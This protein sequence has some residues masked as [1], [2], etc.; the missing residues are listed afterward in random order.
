M[1]IKIILIFFLTFNSLFSQNPTYDWTKHLS[2]GGSF[3]E[4][5]GVDHDSSGN[6][7]TVGYFNSVMDFDPSSSNYI[8]SSKGKDDMFIQKLDGNGNFIWAVSFG[9]SEYSDIATDVRI[10]DDDNV[11]VTG[12]FK[13]SID[14]DP[15]SNVYEVI[16]ANYYKNFVLKLNNSGNLIWVKAFGRTSYSS[17]YSSV[18]VDNSGNIYTTGYFRDTAD[19]NPS[20]DTF[21]V[22]SNG[23]S[24]VF[25]HKLDYQGN[26]SWVR[27]MGGQY[28]DIGHSIV[29]SNSGYVYSTGEFLSTVDFNTDRGTYYRTSNGIRDYY[30]HKLDING[31]FVWA[32]TAGGFANEI[33][34]GIVLDTNE[35]VYFV[36]YM[37]D[38]ADFDPSDA[39]Y[40]VEIDGNYNAFIAKLNSKGDFQWAK[41]IGGTN[42]RSIANDIA[43]DNENKLYVVGTFQYTADFDF[44]TETYPLTSNGEDDF[45]ALKIDQDSNFIWAKPIGGLKWDI[46]YGVQTGLLNELY[47][48]GAFMNSVDFNFTSNADIKVGSYYSLAYKIFTTK[49]KNQEVL[50]IGTHNS[51]K[52]FVFPNPSREKVNLNFTK[53]I[54]KINASIWSLSGKLLFQ[55]TFQNVDNIEVNLKSFSKGIYYLNLKSNKIKET[56]KLIIN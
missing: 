33:S 3:N 18:D 31:N 2:G 6:V 13:G 44:S 51:L 25:I 40:N 36:G 53:N 19:F 42:V 11:I 50:N 23:Y 38:T 32:K 17:D 15:S 1:K 5:L 4:G 14:F 55:K 20:T 48:T 52:S 47:I 56:H 12:F 43:I 16:A 24:D 35:N 46:A 10:D 7:Y 28:H 26:F 54:K 45:F 41:N 27:T 8:L 29:V 34:K 49:W 22:T 21:N 39:T 30:V 9:S 37:E